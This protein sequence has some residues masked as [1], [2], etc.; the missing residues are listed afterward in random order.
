MHF[1]FFLDT[2]H[3]SLLTVKKVAN[4]SQGHQRCLAPCNLPTLE[5]RLLTFPFCGEKPYLI[6]I[7]IHVLWLW[8]WLGLSS[9]LLAASFVSFFCEWSYS[10]PAWWSFC[11]WAVSVLSSVDA[12][13]WAVPWGVTVPLPQPAS[14]FHMASFSYAVP[15]M[16]TAD[17]LLFYSFWAFCHVYRCLPGPPDTY[18]L[19]DI[20][21]SELLGSKNIF[22]FLTFQI[23]R[24]FWFVCFVFKSSIEIC[25]KW[26]K[27]LILWYPVWLL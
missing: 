17:S 18:A 21:L 11:S 8:T 19:Q 10:S 12:R 5:S 6:A 26:G 15:R 3:Q 4:T 1:F 22:F 14:V 9:G 27:S 23:W 24:L 2:Y 13:T 16:L 20:L 25:L 7:Y